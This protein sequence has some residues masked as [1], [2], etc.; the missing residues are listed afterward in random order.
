MAADNTCKACNSGCAECS[1]F[2]CTKARPYYFLKEGKPVSCPDNCRACSTDGKC[3]ECSVGYGIKSAD[4]TC[5]I[6]S[7]IKTG[8]RA[9]K[10]SKCT[11]CLANSALGSVYNLINDNCVEC[12]VGCDKCSD[13]K[14]CIECFK[15]I[16][17]QA[18][19]SCKYMTVSDCF[20]VGDA[21]DKCKTCNPVYRLSA[22]RTKCDYINCG[23]GQGWD[24]EG[25]CVPT[26][27][28]KCKSSDERDKRCIE[29]VTDTTL[30]EK[31]PNH[32]RRAS[33]VLNQILR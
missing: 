1:E 28:L 21:I 17:P 3:T 6:C 4:G 19:K 29:P 16:V 25:K 9:C 27:I 10:D 18:D 30:Q 26:T 15:I 7:S 2:K 31:K 12:P 24:A 11:A 8:C 23:S 5:E 22:D 32:V 33:A 14:T 20:E 13:S